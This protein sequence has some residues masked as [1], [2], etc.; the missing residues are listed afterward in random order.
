MKRIT[1]I[2]LFATMGMLCF[3]R[4]PKIVNIPAHEARYNNQIDPIDINTISKQFVKYLSSLKWFNKSKK[5]FWLISPKLLNKT[6]EHLQ[7][8]IIA[9][10]ISSKLLNKGIMLKDG[11][12]ILNSI[13]QDPYLKKMNTWQQLETKFKIS[14]IITGQVTNIRKH[15]NERIKV[16]YTFTF[17]VI[18]VKNKHVVCIKQIIITKEYSKSR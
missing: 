8:S 3:S 15:D 12:I 5:Y 14:Y 10:K 13:L 9:N 7:T 11:N 1:L 4:N 17:K 2:M 18:K 6:D 16:S